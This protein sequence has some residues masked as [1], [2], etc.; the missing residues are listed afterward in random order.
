MLPPPRARLFSGYYFITQAIV[1]ESGKSESVESS[2]SSAIWS[3]LHIQFPILTVYVR[4]QVSKREYVIIAQFSPILFLHTC[5][6]FVGRRE[7]L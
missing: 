5:I 6:G 1:C 2:P 4:P 3:V 7:L